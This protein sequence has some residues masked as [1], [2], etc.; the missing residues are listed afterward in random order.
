MGAVTHRC[1][2]CDSDY[3]CDTFEQGENEHGHAVYRCE[4]KS[5]D[6]C[7]GCSQNGACESCQRHPAMGEHPQ[8][9]LCAECLSEW[10]DNHAEVA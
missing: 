3:P 6:E 2:W 8:P 4:C 10:I 1:Q 5:K 9:W 7:P